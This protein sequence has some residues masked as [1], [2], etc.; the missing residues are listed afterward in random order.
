MTLLLATRTLVGEAQVDSTV[1]NN[2]LEAIQESRSKF[3]P[4]KRTRIVELGAV[5]IPSNRYHIRSTEPEALSYLKQR[6]QN[7]AAGLT[8]SLLPDSSVADTRFGVINLSV[9]NLRTE[10]S[11]AAEMA[12]QLLLGTAVDILET[13]S[14]D[15]R[16][17]T[18]E[19]YIAWVPKHSATAMNEKDF[20]DWKSTK[21]II[22]TN[23]FGKSY[24]KADPTSQRVSDLVFGNVLIAEAVTD[25]FYKVRYPDGRKAYIPS[26]EGQSFESWMNSRQLTTA[27]ILQSAKTMLGLPYLWGG[28]SVKGVDCSGFTKT[29][30]YMNGYIIPR[31]ASQQIL[32]GNQ[33]D[34]LDHKGDFDPQKALQSLQPG[35]LL[36]FAA[37]K[38]QRP[39]PR[40]THVAIYIGNGEFIHAA[41][42]VRINSFMADRNNYDD[43]Q[44]RTVIGAKRYMNSS[45]PLIQKISLS[46]YY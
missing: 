39:N 35:D 30:F 43:F 40:V 3:A 2:V 44:T 24:S 23:E 46:R 14:S 17:R 7:N 12:T 32:A 33:V 8:Y 36:F 5:D 9:A 34:I 19:G 18:P 37:G 45:D 41:G 6:L 27:N 11:H 10:P 25:N 1:Y 26:N 13:R 38:N 15:Y 4:D 42:S 31:D 20:A 16:V 28:T 21:K 22:Y 29:V